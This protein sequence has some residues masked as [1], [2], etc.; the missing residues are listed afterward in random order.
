VGACSEFWTPQVGLSAAL[1]ICKTS[2][3]AF[4]ARDVEDNFFLPLSLEVAH[5]LILREEHLALCFCS[6]FASLKVEFED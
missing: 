5:Q 3:A 1:V 4:L 6:Y 2:V